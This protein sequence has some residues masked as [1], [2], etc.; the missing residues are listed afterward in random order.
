MT[1]DEKQNLFTCEYCQ[2]RIQGPPI[3]TLNRNHCP[4]CLWSKHVDKLEAGDRAAK[5]QKMMEPIGL[6]FKHEG[7]D[8]F[9]KPKQGELM[10][11]HQC[12]G[13]GKISINRIAGDDANKMILKIFGNSQ[14]LAQ[15]TLNK[16]VKQN[17]QVL[18]KSSKDQILAHIYGKD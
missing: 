6:T 3:G 18:K 8:K 14:K 1:N 16:L 7:F 15:T 11:I 12:Q 9:G 2:K 5:C 4:F 10:L 17:I 13:C